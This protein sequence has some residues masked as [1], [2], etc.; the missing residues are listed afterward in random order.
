M[1]TTVRSL[2]RSKNWMIQ[3]QINSSNRARAKSMMMMMIKT[4]LS[5]LMRCN[6]ATLNLN[7]LWRILT[8]RS[9]ISCQHLLLMVAT[10]RKI[11]MTKTG[12]KMTTPTLKKTRWS[13]SKIPWIVASTIIDI[14]WQKSSK[15]RKIIN[16]RNWKYMTEIWLNKVYEE[17]NTPQ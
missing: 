3:T 10:S 2:S 9:S 4:I 17:N 8:T 11:T 16:E 14:N 5:S 1:L 12:W 13:P 7:Q 15:T 6:R